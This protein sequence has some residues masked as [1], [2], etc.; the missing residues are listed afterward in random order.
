[1]IPKMYQPGEKIVNKV[2]NKSYTLVKILGVG[3][4]GQVYEA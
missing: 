4:S 3:A 2:D 1:M